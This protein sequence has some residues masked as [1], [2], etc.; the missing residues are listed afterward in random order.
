MSCLGRL[1]RRIL[2]LRGLYN[3]DWLFSDV[4]FALGH[5]STKPRDPLEHPSIV[6]RNG[7]G[8]PHRRGAVWSP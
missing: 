4:V 3:I 7:Q 5:S 1:A 8:V 2:N 6:I